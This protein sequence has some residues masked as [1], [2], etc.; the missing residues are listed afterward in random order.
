MRHAIVFMAVLA[1]CENT[2][3]GTDAATSVD[4]PTV[5][6]PTVDTPT[7]D[8]PMVDTPAVDTPAV[9]VPAIDARDAAMDASDVECPTGLTRCPSDGGPVCVDTNSDRNHC[10]GCG[11]TCCAGTACFGGSCPLGCSP[12]N[13]RCGCV[14]VNPSFDPMN[15]GACGN[16]CPAGS[17]CAA[18]RCTRLDAGADAVGCAMVSEAPA[19]SGQCD[20]RGRI[21]CTNWANAMFDGGT[22]FATCV[23]TPAGCMRA[24]SCEDITDTSTCRCG[25]SPT[26]APGQVCATAPGESTPSCR[27]IAN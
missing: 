2:V 25:T 26:C 16:A 19:P 1:A 20:G 27:C 24:D 8:T 17:I 12:G 9:D 7:V 15:C 14:C 13:I 10:G 22:A 6:A 11:R 5:D 18:G 23:S 4:T 21:A 3:T